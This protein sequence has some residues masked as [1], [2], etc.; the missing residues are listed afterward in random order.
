M[1]TNVIKWFNVILFKLQSII[2][3]VPKPTCDPVTFESQNVKFINQN[4]TYIDRGQGEYFLN[5]GEEGFQSFGGVS[6]EIK[7]RL[8]AF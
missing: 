1:N 4:M 5:Q 6:W 3:D 7:L 2:C 8:E